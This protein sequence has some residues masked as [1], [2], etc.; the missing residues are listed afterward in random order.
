MDEDD[1]LFLDDSGR[2]GA[3]MEILKL[4]LIHW[5]VVCYMVGRGV[6][7]R[8]CPRTWTTSSPRRG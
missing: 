3:G 5:M 4:C 6:R 1:S 7:R 2:G 8:G